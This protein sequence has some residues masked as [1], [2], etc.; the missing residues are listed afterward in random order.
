MTP[1]RVVMLARMTL[2][3]TVWLCAPILIV[4]I[5]VGLVTSV[6][7]VMTSIQEMTIGTVPRLA[8]V[9]LVTYIM[10]PWLMRKLLA[11]ALLLF[12]NFR[13]YLG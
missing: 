10:M 11:F 2:E 13:P 12:S 3:V 9:G 1:E 5:I 4:A 7:Q 6:L 8:A